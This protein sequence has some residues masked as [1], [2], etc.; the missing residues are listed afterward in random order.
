MT[1]RKT[2]QVKIRFV[3]QYTNWAGNVFRPY[4]AADGRVT[5]VRVRTG[6]E[7]LDGSGCHDMTN[8]EAKETAIWRLTARPG[9]VRFAR[10]L[11]N[12]FTGLTW[13]VY[14]G[15]DGFDVSIRTSPGGFPGGRKLTREQTRAEALHRLGVAR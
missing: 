13:H 4:E 12:H 2:P 7:G 14:E 3:R 1:G 11:T 5:E 6:R 15:C 9:S 8:A 10:E